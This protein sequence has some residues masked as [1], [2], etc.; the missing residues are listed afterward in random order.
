MRHFC[1]LLPAVKSEFDSFEDVVEAFEAVGSDSTILDQV[2]LTSA[3]LD[4]LENGVGE[5]LERDE[6]CLFALP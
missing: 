3:R 1:E 2:T 6:V 5:V 4:V